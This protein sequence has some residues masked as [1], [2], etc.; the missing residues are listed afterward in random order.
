[1]SDSKPPAGTFFHLLAKFHVL[2]FDFSYLEG[3]G[4]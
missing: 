3:R 4:G 1:M 2:G